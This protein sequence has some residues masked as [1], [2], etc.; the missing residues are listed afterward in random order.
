M[1]IASYQE[2]VDQR[3]LPQALD[4]VIPF[5]PTLDAITRAS[6]VLVLLKREEEALELWESRL[7]L[8][9]DC[10]DAL[11]N[12]ARLLAAKKDTDHL[13]KKDGLPE[14]T[15]SSIVVSKLSIRQSEYT[16]ALSQLP[17]VEEGETIESLV[18]KGLLALRVEDIE[19]SLSLLSAALEM[20]RGEGLPM[21]TYLQAAMLG[22]GE[23]H[24]ALGHYDSALESFNLAVNTSSMHSGSPSLATL[25]GRARSLN[26]MQQSVKALKEYSAILKLY[27]ECLEAWMHRAELHARS[28]ET[29]AHAIRDYTR[30]L[31]LQPGHTMA[32][33][34]RA[35]VF[36]ESGEFVKSLEDLNQC[37][38]IDPEFYQAREMMAEV[39]FAMGND[40]LAIRGFSEIILHP[41]SSTSDALYGRS[42]ALLRSGRFA[43]AFDDIDQ[44]IS[45]LGSTKAEHFKARGSIL[46]E[47]E[48]YHEAVLDF[49]TVLQRN[50]HHALAL[51]SRGRALLYES[52]NEEA[53]SDF[54][55]ALRLRKS[56]HAHCRFFIG[57]CY[58]EMGML[59]SAVQSFGDSISEREN[60]Y[61]GFLGRGLALCLNEKWSSA[62]EDLRHTLDICEELLIDPPAQ[63][64]FL[65][66]TSLLHIQ[67]YT[68]AL[69]AFDLYMGA[70]VNEDVDDVHS[71]PHGC[72]SVIA[73]ATTRSR[74]ED[75]N[76]FLLRAE[77]WM[78]LH[79]YPEAVN[80][81][82]RGLGLASIDEEPDMVLEIYLLRCKANLLSNKLKP[83]LSD[84]EC[85]LSING[86]SIEGLVLKARILIA[87]N[88][89]ESA[90][91]LLQIVEQLNPQH[92]ETLGLLGQ[93]H[94]CLGNYKD[95]KR[96]LDAAIQLDE[97]NLLPFLFRGAVEMLSEGSFEIADIALLRA[98]KHDPN[99]SIS[100]YTRG[101]LHACANKYQSALTIVE[102]LLD[103][104][105]GYSEA[106]P[107]YEYILETLD[108]E[109]RTVPQ[110]LAAESVIFTD[111]LM[112]KLIVLVST[113]V[114][115]METYGDGNTGDSANNSSEDD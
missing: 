90:F 103:L 109:V 23:A 108:N 57:I 71:D 95:A 25:L 69:N 62:L 44:L 99:S 49:T 10:Q 11:L 72:V 106:Y 14:C 78:G 43:Q 36:R 102:H 59:T 52:R 2:L 93:L 63:A 27:P 45:G 15:A 58:I 40:D 41:S 87:E 35:G 83:A 24:Y 31:V 54:Q 112:Q 70:L 77:C 86:R 114:V 20:A 68:S 67:E 66:G 91:N 26:Q 9:P 100:L 22:L 5:V 73:M 107:L 55:S 79:Q 92:V 101:K 38:T 110:D 113:C 81:L 65:K 21:N 34:A 8:V 88:N 30:V 47:L 18:L 33:Y 37:I 105:P 104:H 28:S 48:H 42:L 29:V 39:H 7:K 75:A 19:L 97:C 4:L 60:F 89:L 56:L 82:S 76:P 74:F 13:Q 32:M 51:F 85:A 111:H 1:D 3:R 61:Y 96:V 115:S 17:G 84:V 98:L 46:F 53:I 50:P 12:R 80:D 64:L 6:N 16:A 94:V